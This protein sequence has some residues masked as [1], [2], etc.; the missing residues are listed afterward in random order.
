[1]KYWN[2]GGRAPLWFVVDPVRAGIDLVQHGDPVRYRWPVPYPV[3]LSGVRPHEMDWYRVDQPEWYVGEGWALTP[4]TAGVADA[5]RRGPSLAPIEG[6]I[7]RGVLG[8]AL[9]IGGRNFDPALKP[10]LTVRIDGR[11]VAEPTLEPGPFLRVVS[12]PAD[13]VAAGDPRAYLNMTV[14]AS[15]GSRLAVEQFDASVKRSL[16][17]F[18]DGWHEPEL[19]PRT[20]A[21][22]RWLSERGELQA[23]LP[24]KRLSLDRLESP[25]VTL[26]LQGESPLTYFSGPSTLTIRSAGRVVFTRVLNADFV[27]D[28][29]VPDPRL[30]PIVL[31]TDQT[32][33]PADRSRRSADR[34]HLGLR[35]FRVWL[36]T[37][38]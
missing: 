12:L 8:G 9:M 35:I 20:G 27:I 10:R 17:G 16:V 31:E 2:G 38:S 4:E 32:F 14:E 15:A 11:A 23:W 13:L 6:W 19:N 24:V 26:H 33:S 3:L 29:P 34:R 30:G 25:N 21:R 22:W 5:D 36:T 28:L 37:A 18:G 1:V 7:H